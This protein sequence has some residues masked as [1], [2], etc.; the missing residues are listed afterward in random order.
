MLD[1]GMVTDSRDRSSLQNMVTVLPTLP[2]CIDLM[3]CY[4]DVT[5]N[6]CPDVLSTG[7][8]ALVNASFPISFDNILDV[9]VTSCAFNQSNIH[10]C[11]LE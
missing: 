8:T 10:I 11:R 6:V 1:G 5:V 2:A 9:R 4:R 7:A 3:F